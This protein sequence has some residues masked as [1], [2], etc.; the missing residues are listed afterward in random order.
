ML[1]H[2]GADDS[3]RHGV[4]TLYMFKLRIVGNLEKMRMIKSLPC[5]TST[6]VEPPNC[7]D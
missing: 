6:Y 1:G 7:D 2:I 4:W 5:P 3:E